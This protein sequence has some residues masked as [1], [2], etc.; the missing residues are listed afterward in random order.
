MRKIITKVK[1]QEE[2]MAKVIGRRYR[3][4]YSYEERRRA[5]EV[6]LDNNMNYSDA[7]RITGIMRA[8]LRKWVTMYSSVIVPDLEARESI[9]LV[10][11]KTGQEVQEAFPEEI[12]KTKSVLL[13]RINQ[14][15]PTEQDMRKLTDALEILHNIS[16]EKGGKDKGG[17]SEL[18]KKW[19]SQVNIAISTLNNQMGN[20][21]GS[22]KGSNG[23]N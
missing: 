20:G 2:G 22:T 5:V 8:T 17:E 19:N 6:V 12:I 13:Q 3:N 10:M 7:E 11:T 9:A 15:A 21:N 1:E 18:M 14:L 16:T 4:N 23:R